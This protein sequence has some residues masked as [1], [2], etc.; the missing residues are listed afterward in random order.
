VA[1]YGF[2]VPIQSGMTERDREFAAELN[3]PRKAEF[4]ASRARLGITR[5]QVWLQETP[6]ITF[7]VV[8]LEAENI[9]RALMGLAT[10]QE[11][12]DQ[13]WHEQIKAIHG[14]DLTQPPPGPPNE[15][16]MDFSRG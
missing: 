9:E 8:Y 13:W 10:S 14:I 5:E 15:Q 2:V 3:G 16:I 1:S 6:Q 7:A 11:P 4:E 12:F